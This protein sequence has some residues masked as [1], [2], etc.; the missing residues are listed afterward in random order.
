MADDTQMAPMPQQAAAPQQAPEQQPA[1]APSD[2]GKDKK[3]TKEEETDLKIAV[4]LA[5]HVIDQGGI[6]V[7]DQAVKESSDP[8]QVIG[9]FLMQLVSQTSEQLPKEV[10]LSPRIYFAHGGW[11]EQISDYLQDT[12]KIP[13]KIMDRAEVYIAT[14][15]QK[16]SQGAAQQAAQGQPPATEAPAGGAPPMPQQAAMQG[17]A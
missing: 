3:L 15:A 8:G 13:R 16:M 9:Q 12:Y 17:G 5:Q 7:I 1:P 6:H 11:V 10:S 14:A 4:L 2:E